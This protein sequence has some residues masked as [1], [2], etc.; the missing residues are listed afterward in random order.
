MGACSADW[1]WRIALLS[2]SCALTLSRSLADRVA[3]DRRAQGRQVWH[4]HCPALP[5]SHGYSWRP[6]HR[7]LERYDRGV[8]R[9]LRYQPRPPP[10]RFPSPGIFIFFSCC[11]I[12]A[13]FVWGKGVARTYVYDTK[14][15]ARH[16]RI[17]DDKLSIICVYGFFSAC[18]APAH[19]TVSARV[20][21]DCVSVL[22]GDHHVCCLRFWMYHP[23]RHGRCAVC[24]SHQEVW[25]RGPCREQECLTMAT[26]VHGDCIRL[27]KLHSW[28][29]YMLIE[30]ECSSMVMGAVGDVI[31]RNVVVCICLKRH[32]GVS[33]GYWGFCW[34]TA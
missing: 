23:V 11:H 32:S 34:G 21:V 20:C 4:L 3:D 8:R 30:V 1:W 18:S 33:L 13:L 16:I 12:Y 25:V 14:N 24:R 9:F 29:S 6:R 28:G 27:A 15:G 10:R 5:P 2:F 26:Y 17:S 7:A 19:Y 31:K 22:T